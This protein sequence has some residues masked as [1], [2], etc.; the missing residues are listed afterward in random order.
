MYP[1][2]LKSAINFNGGGFDNH[3]IF[4]NNLTPNGG[5]EPQGFYCRGNK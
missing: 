3:R 4:W 1:S 2:E 5:G